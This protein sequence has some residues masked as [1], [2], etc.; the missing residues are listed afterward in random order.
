MSK[1]P[2]PLYNIDYFHCAEH[3]SSPPAELVSVIITSYNYQQYVIET[4]ESVAAQ[5]HGPIELVIVD[6]KSP[7]DSLEVIRTWLMANHARFHRIVLAS[8]YVNQGLGQSRN[9]AVHFT[10]G[11][12][13]FVLDSDNIIFPTCIERHA[14]VLDRNDAQLAYCAFERFGS[15]KHIGYADFWDK[16]KLKFGNYI[17]AMA[18]Y[19][20]E[21]WTSVGGYSYFDVMGWED[22]DLWCKFMDRGYKGIFIPEILCRYRVH[23]SSMTFTETIPK[24]LR[25]AV[26]LT[27][28]HPWLDLEPTG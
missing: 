23:G 25:L 6:D 28:H 13:V 14:E 2:L 9:S 15:E 22:Y 11:S 20:K 26:E 7:D 27:S 3:V 10:T 18:M 17:D 5:T 21:A 1:L 19:S 16:D 24:G 4:L 8:P 12:K